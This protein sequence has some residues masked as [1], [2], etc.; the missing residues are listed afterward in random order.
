MLIFGA[1]QIILSQIR[2][3]DELWFMSI[4]VALVSFGYSSIGLG[5]AVG[6]TS[7]TASAD[8]LYLTTTHARQLSCDILLALL[9]LCVRLHMLCHFQVRWQR[10][11]SHERRGHLAV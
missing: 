5:L 2:N 3:L 9:L 4:I 8:D 7:G 6:K 10:E 1:C 11:V